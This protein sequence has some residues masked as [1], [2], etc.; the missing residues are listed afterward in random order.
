[1][2]GKNVKRMD[3]SLN[4]LLNLVYDM[5]FD[6]LIN[7]EKGVIST[8]IQKIRVSH[9]KS[10][11]MDV[12]I[13]PGSEEECWIVQSENKESIGYYELRILDRNCGCKLR[14]D[15]CNIC[16]HYYSCTCHDY[17][18]RSNLC[19]HIHYLCKFIRDNHKNK[20][21]HLDNLTINEDQFQ[22]DAHRKTIVDNIIEI[23][24][25]NDFST[26]D[27]MNEKQKLIEKMSN[28]INS[29]KNIDEIKVIKGIVTSIEPT[30]NALRVKDRDNINE[31]IE[32][33]NSNKRNIEKQRFYS[34]KKKKKTKINSYSASQL[35][36]NA[37]NVI[38][39]S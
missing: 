26:N 15:N 4:L 17:L 12:I 33:S 36:N 10:E 8:R 22:L 38:N 29:C 5:M 23:N 35:I 21:N 19:K 2:N 16:I 3:H 32:K 39:S 14:C 30:I 25:Q 34:T 37:L 13:I 9:N 11:Q 1:M 6:R 20:D 7:I 18:I 28:I 27:L 24:S 31:L